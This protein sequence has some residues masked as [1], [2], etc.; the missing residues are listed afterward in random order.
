L[1]KAKENI[2]RKYTALKHGKA[3]IHSLVSETL[4]PI[5]EPLKEIKR[6]K[7]PTFQPQIAELDSKTINESEDTLDSEVLLDFLDSSNRD[8][9]Y[10]PKTQS[11]GAIH[12]G[13]KEIKL[14]DQTLT[15]E[16]T[17]YPLTRGL[18]SLIFL[19]IPKSYTADDL[20]TYK[21]ILIQT[22]AHL[23]L[24]EKKN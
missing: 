22:S 24:D 15:I 5:I 12:L 17:A 8:K 16:D 19:K 13:K 9:K 2:K 11:S 10:G 21:T 7:P 1:I 3:D 23:I 4:Y 14:T 18:S 20:N 6:N